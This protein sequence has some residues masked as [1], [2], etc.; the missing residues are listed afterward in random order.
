MS[1][2]GDMTNVILCVQSKKRKEEFHMNAMDKI[3]GY[4]E[5][6][7]ELMQISDILKN[8][9]AYEKLGV[10]APRGLLLHGEPG[11]GKSLMA[12]AIIEA[13]GRAV[14][15]CRKDKPNGDF[16]KHIKKIFDE[17]AEN[18]PSIVYLD[19]MDKFT[20]GDERHPDAEEYV[21]V[22]SCIDE[23]KGKQVFVL[24]TV[25]NIRNLPRSLYRA[26]RF[27]RVIEVEPP[28]GK[29]AENIIFHYLNS[30][31]FV[32]DI[33]AQ[34]IARIMDGRS[35]AELEMVINEAGLYAGYERCDSITMDHFMKACLR[36]IFDVPTKCN[37]DGEDVYCT[38]LSDAQSMAAQ[39]V[40]HEAGHTVVSEVICPRSVTLVCAYSRHGNKNGFTSYYN[41]HSQ[42]PLQWRK[43][44]LVGS[45]AGMAAVE[46]VFGMNDI[47]NQ[48]DLDKAFSL[49]R[50]LVEKNCICG[51]HF[52]HNGYEDSQHLWGEQE[53]AISCEIEKYYKKA[54][55][56]LARNKDF[57]EKI[58]AALAKK[59]LLTMADIEAIKST[60]QIT[61]VAL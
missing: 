33:D 55:E 21:T 15:T 36:T 32:E 35:C 31:K 17:A 9:D 20:N 18:T 28:C 39:V 51:F 19:D 38:D 11:V 14:Y 52:H 50:E 46:Q 47:G 45:L 1:A 12:A 37:T 34:T 25:N 26:G 4:A 29:D 54:K 5:L 22:Q 23:V 49:A 3:I 8:R 48:S 2:F 30:K 61:P 56:I 24:A 60:C 40:Y 13:S 27:D 43:Y 42:N 10:S 16:I 57:L 44:R 58:A 6:K 7:Q 59:G 41:D 53:Q